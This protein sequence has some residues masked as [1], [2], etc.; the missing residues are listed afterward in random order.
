MAT[1]ATATTSGLENAKATTMKAIV[2]ERYGPVESLE[3]KEIEIPPVGDDRVLVRVRAAS[4]NPVDWRLLRGKPYSARLMGMGLLRPRSTAVGTDVAGVVE[5]VGKDVTELRPGD[6]VFGARDGA[7]AEYVLGRERNFVPKPA[8]RSFEEAAAIPIAA[9]TALQALRDKGQLQ[10]G[11]RALINGA[12]GG[13]GTF[14]V[15]I[16]KALGAHVT[17][18]CSTRNVEMVRSLGA[19]EVVDYTREDFARHGQRYDLVVDNVGNRALRHLRRALTPDGTLVI[20]GAKKSRWMLGLI[21]LSLRAKLMSRFVRRRLIGLWI[22]KLNKPDLVTLKEMVEA[23]KITP[24][25]DR[26]YPLSEAREAIRYAEGGHARAK[27]VITV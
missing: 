12:A 4:V 16:A 14:T 13:V 25:V 15:Q 20:V 17:G 11:Q 18:V 8:G 5:A 6:E 22:A 26:T 9:I 3:L 2:Q 1:T 10:P 7:F 23:G 27:V 19:D 24:V 21:G